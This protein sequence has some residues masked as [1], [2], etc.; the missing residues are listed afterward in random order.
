MYKSM[1]V[2]QSKLGKI[3]I[4]VTEQEK[5]ADAERDIEIMEPLNPGYK[6]AVLDEK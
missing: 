6:F 4:P 5:K 1:I 3:Y 2:V